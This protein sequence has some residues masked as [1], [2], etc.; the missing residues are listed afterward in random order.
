[1]NATVAAVV[2]CSYCWPLEPS[3][4]QYRAGMRTARPG[5]AGAEMSPIAAAP[6]VAR[7]RAL[8]MPVAWVDVRCRP[9]PR[10]NGRTP[11]LPSTGGVAWAL[12]ATAKHG[13]PQSS[14]RDNETQHEFRTVGYG[15]EL[16]M[17]AHVRESSLS[18]W[19]SPR[20]RISLT[21]LGV[22]TTWPLSRRSRV[23]DRRG[24]AA[25]AKKGTCMTDG[26][27]PSA[28][29]PRTTRH[30]R[31]ANGPLASADVGHVE[32]RGGRRATLA[33]FGRGLCLPHI[34][35]YQW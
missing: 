16:W 20:T 33:A 25:R 5:A 24:R 9:R 19:P 28:R 1:M 17:W 4:Q 21:R 2:V 22:R 11:P 3:Y 26:E 29:R 31:L 15:F 23:A 27:R 12:Q 32:S 6:A 10:S 14:T 18:L 8:P 35:P 13:A 7:A 34:L 30:T